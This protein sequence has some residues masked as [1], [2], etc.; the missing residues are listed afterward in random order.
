MKLKP[1]LKL[2][3]EE[4]EFFKNKEIFNTLEKKSVKVVYSKKN[5]SNKKLKKT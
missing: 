2:T 1:S 4:I 5:I 3:P